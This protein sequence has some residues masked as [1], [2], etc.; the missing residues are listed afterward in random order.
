MKKL[1]ITLLLSNFCIILIAQNFTKKNIA[2]TTISNNLNK[3][4]YQSEYNNQ[5]GN[6]YYAIN[7]LPKGYSKRGNIDYT[8]YLQNAIDKHSIVI[9]PNFPVLISDKGLNL[10]SNQVVLFQ[11][12]SKLVLKPTAKGYYDMLNI[13]QK[14]NVKIYYAN[15]EGDRY[16]H[17]G[18]KGQWGFGIAIK[19]SKNIQIYSPF[20]ENMWGDGIYVGQVNNIPSKDIVISNAFINSSRRNGI[21]VTS[22]NGVNIIDCFISNTYGNSPESGLDIE[23]NTINDE[24][25]NITIKNLTTFNN[26]W[27]GVLMVFELLKSKNIKDIS[28]KIDGHKDDGSQNAISFH[29]YLNDSKS[30]NLEGEINLQNV[31]Y[32]NNK[33]KYY[34]YKSNLSRI[35]LITSDPELKTRFN[36]FKVK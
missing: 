18:K 25:K 10:N 1:L 26:K 24:I 9:L 28:V 14:S 3:N 32:K 23:P 6:G 4:K 11:P 29:G 21:S 36:K 8:E 35:N 30:N 12:Q 13:T 20:I 16:T 7:S 31:N 5:K 34:F 17:L 19:S 15:L 2:T 33:N 27:S 22:A